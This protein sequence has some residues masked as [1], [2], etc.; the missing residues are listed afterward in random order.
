[1]ISLVPNRARASAGTAAQA[2][3][4]AMPAARTTATPTAP[5][6]ASPIASATPAQQIAAGDELAF[7]PHVVEPEAERHRRRQAR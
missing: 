1:M 2:A 3:P 6:S 7:G 4:P 5:G